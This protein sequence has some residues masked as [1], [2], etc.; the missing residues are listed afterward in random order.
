MHISWCLIDTLVTTD[1]QK[2][3]KMCISRESRAHIFQTCASLD[4]SNKSVH[5]IVNNDGYLSNDSSI[6]LIQFS[7]KP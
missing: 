5:Y 6:Y 3:Q 4:S 1:P 2:M 7:T